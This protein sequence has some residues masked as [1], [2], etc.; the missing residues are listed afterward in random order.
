M[1]AGRKRG[2]DGRTA[3]ATLPSEKR[4]RGRPRQNREPATSGRSSDLTGGVE[5]LTQL[6][7]TALQTSD[8]MDL[9]EIVLA[10]RT[11][12]TSDVVYGVL[13]VLIVTGIVVRVSLAEDSQEQSPTPTRGRRSFYA[14]RSFCKSS[15][16]VDIRLLNGPQ[17]LEEKERSISQ[18]EA[19]IEALQLLAASS[20]DARDRAEALKTFIQ[21]S[22]VD[23]KGLAPN[24]L[25]SALSNA[26]TTGRSYS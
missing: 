11:H 2:V 18:L 4:S 23:N 10:T 13:E 14:L 19:R 22:L 16:G 5:R 24:P 8:P 7:L 21:R 15:E 12:Y 25:Y 20:L 26:F 3:G 9:S 1:E 17:V 6:I